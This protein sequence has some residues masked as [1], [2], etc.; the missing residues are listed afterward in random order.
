M[1]LLNNETLTERVDVN[2]SMTID[3]NDKTITST[4]TCENGSAFNVKSGEVTIKN[5][6]I[7]GQAGPTGWT[8]ELYEMECD[9]ITVNKGAIVNLENLEISICSQT[10]ACVYAFDGGKVNVTSGTYSNATDKYDANGKTKAMLLNQADEKNQA[11]FV[12]GGTFIGE[13]PAN[14]DNSG[15]PT[16]F[17]AENCQSTQTTIDGKKTAWIVTAK[18]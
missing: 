4:E 14:G 1:T 13:N 12:T 9:A 17:L 8:E 7:I 2:A 16:T 18:A 6:T 5:G 15:N 3:L 11:I 10:G